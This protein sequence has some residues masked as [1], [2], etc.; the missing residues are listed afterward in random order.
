MSKAER[1]FARVYY[2]DLERD[3]PTTFYDPTALST[4]LRLLILSE[5]AWPALPDLPT[6]IRR[7]D[8]KTLEAD[9][10][11]EAQPNGQFL[12]R[13]WRKEREKRATQSLP[14]V[15]TKVDPEVV[16]EVD[17]K[18]SLRARSALSTSTSISSS[19]DGEGVVGETTDERQVF[20]YLAQHGA[21][22]RPD[23][24]LGRRLLGLMERRGVEAVLAEAAEMA[25]VE[26]V[27]SDRQW[28]LGL[29]NG[30]EAIPSG[31]KT[32]EEAVAEEAEARN[33]AR[34]AQVYA[35]MQ[36]RRLEWYRQTGQWDQAWGPKPE[37][38]A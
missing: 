21:A 13:G 16:R 3:H 28:V 12:L 2:V 31:R 37:A 27:M 20:A 26:S 11:Y 34:S 15:T 23:A 36:Q 18:G 24:P 32:P 22:I 25:K 8:L 29:E 10:L 33:E 17:T 4:W 6:S 1:P 5:K 30:L 14:K 35:R 9:N 19:N 7:A 38:V